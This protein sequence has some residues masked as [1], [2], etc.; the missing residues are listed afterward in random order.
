MLSPTR[1]S[2]STFFIHVYVIVD[3]SLTHPIPPPPPLSLLL[4]NI[5]SSRQ[6]PFAFSIVPFDRFFSDLFLSPTSV[7]IEKEKRKKKKNTCDTL[8]QPRKI[9]YEHI[10]SPR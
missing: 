2:P 1:L 3:I 5:T 4:F 10:L 9:E 8:A 6:H 7:K